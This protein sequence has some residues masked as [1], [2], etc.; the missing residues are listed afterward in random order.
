MRAPVRPDI[1]GR[2]AATCR[3]GVFRR[4][5][6]S[7][8]GTEK[9]PV[10][11][12]KG[13]GIMEIFTL[14]KLRQAIESR[15]GQTLASF[16]AD[17]ASL[18]IIDQENPPGRPHEIN[19]RAAIAAWYADVCGRMMT[20]R[21]DSGVREGDRVA[22]TQIC[23]YPDGNRVYCSSNLE[24]DGGKIVRQVSLQVWDP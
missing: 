21:L 3:Q 8:A 12:L 9:Q 6:R 24:L 16:Y 19:G 1:V 11:P 4:R 22:F 14:P 2:H 23:T 17:D 18:R 7:G 10:H 13:D 20:H 15:D 5:S